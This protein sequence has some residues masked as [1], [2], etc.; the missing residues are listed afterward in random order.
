MDDEA[1][2]SDFRWGEADPPT[3][4]LRVEVCLLV[5]FM[6]VEDVILIIEPV[7]G[8]LFAIGSGEVGINI[9][10][11]RVLRIDVTT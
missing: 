5:A 6:F 1:P 10:D 11:F 9:D 8:E 2:C 3:V 7:D 4:V